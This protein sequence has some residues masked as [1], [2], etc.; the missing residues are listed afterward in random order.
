MKFTLES[1][2]NVSVRKVANGQIVIGDQIWSEAIALTGDGVI[3]DWSAVAVENLSIDSL[4]P[5][6]ERNP[7]LIVVGTGS[8]QMLPD[9][10]LMFAMARAGVGLEFMDTPAGA[11]T[12][13]VL[14]GEGRSVAAILYPTS[15]N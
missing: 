5:L 7:E 8:Q 15:A 11:R 2:S 13:N 12:F 4:A 6:L 9:R 1:A 3:D 10:E 14:I